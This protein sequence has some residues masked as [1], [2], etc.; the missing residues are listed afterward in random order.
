MEGFPWDSTVNRFQKRRNTRLTRQRGFP[1][2][3]ED[4]RAVSGDMAIV[5]PVGQGRLQGR[6][7]DLDGRVVR[8]WL[9]VIGCRGVGGHG[10]LLGLDSCHVVSAVLFAFILPIALS[11]VLS[12]RRFLSFYI[13]RLSYLC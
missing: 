1:N 2:A 7:G 6:L 3:S 9:R 12:A 10:G 11:R 13:S 8:L 5:L 4:R